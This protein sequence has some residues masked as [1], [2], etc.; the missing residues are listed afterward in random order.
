[1]KEKLKICYQKL[2]FE[3][4]ITSYKLIFVFIFPVF[5]VAHNRFRDKYLFEPYEYFNILLYYLSYLFSFILLI[6][7]KYINRNNNGIKKEKDLNQRKNSQLSDDENLEFQ[8]PL[9]WI[10]EHNN[11]I[12]TIKSIFII[13][14]LCSASLAYNHF[15]FEAF[16]DKKTIGI[17][18]KIPEFFLLSFIFLKYK[19]YIHHYITFGLNTLTMIT[20]YIITI[21]QSNSE[22]YIGKH[23]WFYFLFSITYCLLLVIGKYYMDKFYSSPYFIMLIIGIIMSGILLIIALIKYY[24]TSESQIFTGFN[25]NV[26]NG[27]S[28]GYLIG[29]IISQFIFNLGLWITVYYFTPCHTIISENMMEI[30]YYIYDY[31]DNKKYWNEKEFYLNFWLFPIFLFINLIFSLIFNEIIIFKCCKL[32]Y[33]TNIRIQEREKKEQN[34]INKFINKIIDEDDDDDIQMTSSSDNFSN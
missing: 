9:S 30:M 13:L 11:K 32:D 14:I 20:K 8:N 1:M 19:Y 26:N 12:K 15:N 2:P 28:I 6:I 18:Y 34:N 24:V 10:V 16:I 3:I 5:G 7:F 21:I 27:K 23:I 25:I 33:Y 4:S 22:E 17:A 29:D 31:S